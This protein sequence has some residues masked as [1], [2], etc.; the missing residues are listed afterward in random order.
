MPELPEVESTVQYLRERMLGLRITEATVLWARTIDRPSHAT[1]RK[2]IGGYSVHDVSRRGK[3]IVIEL[4]KRGQPQ[5]FLL[6]H[7][8]MSGSVDV[9]SQAAPLAKHD[10]VVLKLDNGKE[11]RFNDPRKFGRLY[12]VSSPQTVLGKLG[13][14]PLEDSLSVELLYERLQRKRG[15]IKSILL[16]QTILAGVGNIY[17][18]ECLWRSR[19]H[20]LRRACSLSGSEVE[21][22]LG[23]LRG[24]LQEAIKANGTDFGDGV[25]H[26]GLYVPRVY[27]R[28]GEPCQRCQ[29]PIKRI[30]VGQRGTHFCPNCQTRR[31]SRS[32]LSR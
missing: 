19:V 18:D 17:A 24:T 2:Q 5:R 29:S 31:K 30:V 32:L 16:D 14:E 10:R 12:L 21:R 22:L 8:R 7:L 23:E 27:G 9:I 1:F 20:P 3:Y 13:L 28:D 6:G 15:A 26:E 11:L 4:A 25:I